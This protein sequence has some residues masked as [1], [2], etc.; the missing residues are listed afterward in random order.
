MSQILFIALLVLVVA[1]FVFLYRRK[2]K[3]ENKMGNELNALIESDDWQGV[4]RILRKQLVIWGCVL[5]LVVG[6]IVARFTMGEHTSYVPIIVAV[7]IAWR[8][9]KLVRLYVISYHN[10]KFMNAEEYLSEQPSLDQ[11]L[12]EGNIHGCKITPI[13]ERAA[14]IKQLWLDAYEEGK[15]KG[16]FPVLIDTDTCFYDSLDATACYDDEKF[17]EWKAEM[18]SRNYD[19][20]QAF[21]RERF[22]TIKEDYQEDN[23]DWSEEVVGTEDAVNPI[24]DFDFADGSNIYLVEVPV[25]ESWQVFAYIPFG[26]WNE[27]P[28]ADEQMAVAKYWYE[29]Y[30]A[31]AAHFSND[32]IQ[33]YLPKPVTDDTMSVAEE[34]MGYCE[35]TVLQGDNLTT[36]AA[37][38]KESTVWTFWWD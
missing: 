23:D 24:D 22:N 5:V 2:K 19:D 18:L 27:C 38:I 29:K 15:L 28:D 31:V 30:G 12:F 20:G 1:I 14:D 32:M 6:L 4:C 35:D 37:T 7:F 10:M 21:L 33:Y 11:P 16:F 36:L 26:G 3:V 9:F 34:H 17:N 25:K 8:F 13:D